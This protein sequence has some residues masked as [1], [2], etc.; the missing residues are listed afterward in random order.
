[1]SHRYRRPASIVAALA[2]FLAFVAAPAGALAAPV[3]ETTLTVHFVDAVTLLAIDRA[4]VHVTARQDGAV[5]GEFDGQTDAAG[6]AVLIDLPHEA[7]EGGVVTLDVSAHKST[8]FTDA[9][10]GCVADDTWD[11]AR[12]GIPVDDVALAVEFSEDE[13]QTV[14]S[15]ECPP[16]VVPPTGEV[17]AAQGTPAAARTLPPTDALGDPSRVL[18]LGGV[19]AALVAAG[20][21][22]LVFVAP[23]RRRAR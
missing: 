13:Q 17:G 10:T 15:I 19:V 5:V 11:A 2:C 9:E 12:L 22:A 20:A 4:D 18:D 23:R 21:V 16:Q 7:G 6:V 8:S 3:A 14:S 1:V